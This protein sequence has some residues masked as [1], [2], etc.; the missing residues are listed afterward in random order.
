MAKSKKAYDT[1]GAQ[2]A[3]DAY[4]FRKINDSTF[5]KTYSKK[6]REFLI[7]A[8]E[9]CKHF[10]WGDLQGFLIHEQYE[11]SKDK[12]VA[13]FMAMLIRGNEPFKVMEQMDEMVSII[14]DRPFVWIA[15]RGF[16]EL[17]EP[18]ER[19]RRLP[20]SFVKRGD[21]YRLANLLY[22]CLCDKGS[23]QEGLLNRVVHDRNVSKC[24]AE[25]VSM[26]LAGISADYIHYKVQQL[27]IFLATE[28]RLGLGLWQGLHYDEYP[29]C[30]ESARFV[31]QFTIN[32]PHYY[33]KELVDMM[34][35]GSQLDCYYSYLA[36]CQLKAEHKELLETYEKYFVLHLKK[37][38]MNNR[39]KANFN[40]L[41][42]IWP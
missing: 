28:G 15:N 1:V 35:V 10:A 42:A 3:L 30:R 19:E 11:H 18:N 9:K 8:R 32:E 24:I 23:I 40:R 6:H 29:E 5:Y 31:K 21:I 13:L 16:L 2:D 27:L 36:Y 25:Q 22:D 14:G 17:E 37:R 7:A 20:H 34:N 41:D 26:E 33:F 38:T 39:T 12:E 4:M